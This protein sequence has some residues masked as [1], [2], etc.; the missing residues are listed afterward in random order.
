MHRFRPDRTGGPEGHREKDP[1]DSCRPPGR[2]LRPT[3]AFTLIE[4]LVVVAIIAVL[5]A[6]LMPALENARNRAQQ[7]TCAAHQRQIAM[8]LFMQAQDNDGWMP[9][10][11]GIGGELL[12]KEGKNDEI[13][14]YQYLGGTPPSST[15]RTVDAYGAMNVLWCPGQNEMGPYISPDNCRTNYRF[16][17]ARGHWGDDADSY[18][19]TS[20]GAGKWY[21][22]QG[23]VGN[24]APYRGSDAMPLPNLRMLEKRPIPLS[25]SKQPMTGDM[26]FPLG[27][28]S[29]ISFIGYDPSG[30]PM[31]TYVVAGKVRHNHDA[32]SNASFADGHVSWTPAG[33]EEHD[34]RWYTGRTALFW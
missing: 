7:I 3:G 17:A 11:L 26:F 9:M 22:W 13:S 24:H 21:G 34:M 15:K 33:N 30:Y 6:M 23:F 20:E 1:V 14:L 12:V 31:V 32:G 28:N 8:G 2:R 29:N 16:A 5:A 25:A 18:T 27:P 10:V 19:D 4:L